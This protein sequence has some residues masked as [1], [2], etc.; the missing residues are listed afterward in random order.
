[1]NNTMDTQLMRKIEDYARTLDP[2]NCNL[3]LL[4]MVEEYQRKSHLPYSE[5]ARMTEIPESRLKDLMK[6]QNP[7]LYREEFVAL[8]SGIATPV[9]RLF[10]IPSDLLAEPVNIFPVFRRE[11]TN[12]VLVCM[13]RYEEQ[14]RVSLKEMLDMF[15]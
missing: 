4:R 3:R 11:P 9:D 13:D 7:R 2:V 12:A 15:R 14:D 6:S 1:M 10:E 8:A 5:I